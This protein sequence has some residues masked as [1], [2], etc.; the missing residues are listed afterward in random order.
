[1]KHGNK[2]NLPL[3]RYSYCVFLK[4]AWINITIRYC[5]LFCNN[6]SGI[7]QNSLYFNV[8][9]IGTCCHAKN[10]FVRLIRVDLPDEYIS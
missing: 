1:M 5:F 2:Q 9:L 10:D 8:K 3:N 7:I 4:C 6:I